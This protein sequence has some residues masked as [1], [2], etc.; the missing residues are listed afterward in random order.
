MDWSQFTQGA[1][2]GGKSPWA[3][4]QSY[5]RPATAGGAAPQSAK[6]PLINVDPK[7]AMQVLGHDVNNPTV[8]PI[9]RALESGG[10]RLVGNELVDA[11]GNP[12]SQITNT[13]NDPTGFSVY[14]PSSEGRF[15]FQGDAS[16]KISGTGAG[17]MAYS[18][19]SPGGVLNHLA[20]VAK[21]NP[22]LT[23]AAVA[24]GGYGLAELGA[25][26]GGAA[27]A[28]EGA[29]SAADQAAFD[30]A[31]TLGS[32]AAAP[33]AFGASLAENTLTPTLTDISAESATAYGLNGLPAE[34]FLNV[35]ET[36]I[37]SGLQDLGSVVPSLNVA[38][39]G[40]GAGAGASALSTI[41]D[42]LKA[43]SGGLG[44]VSSGLSIA[45]GLYGLGQAGRT[46][47]AIGQYQ[48]PAGAASQYNPQNAAM[49]EQLLAGKVDV[50]KLP[51]Y[52]AGLQAV[53]RSKA[54]QGYQGSGN[55]ASA[56][57]EY[58]GQFYQQQVQNLLS[59]LG[60][61]GNSAGSAANIAQ[62]SQVSY[63]D[64]LNGSLQALGYGAKGA[65]STL[66]AA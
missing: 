58:G 39:A 23:A 16:G 3:Q 40:G 60:L 20:S 55:M 28:G 10:A 36:A 65:E 18:A 53:E 33:G 32:G 56:V 5:G 25:F 45:S 47:Q 66:E 26:G 46:R 48:G 43:G 19:G 52:E 61:G 14:D 22:L 54:S 11:A 6:N 7:V 35:G 29:L 44:L 24:A 64:L 21:S 13:L 63:L 9:L 12:V 27:A 31:G 1:Q 37:P 8:A 57:A 30:A 17:T 34:P 2:G 42:Y 50:S 41:K 51:G 59:A 15:Y 4:M 38:S 62:S 49:L